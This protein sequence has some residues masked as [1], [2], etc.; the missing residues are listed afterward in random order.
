MTQLPELHRHFEAPNA[1]S[2]AFD[3][4]RNSLVPARNAAPVDHAC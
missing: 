4:F 1:V 3:E 2:G